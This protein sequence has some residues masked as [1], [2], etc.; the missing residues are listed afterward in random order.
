MFTTSGI[1]NKIYLRLITFPNLWS[2]T[3]KIIAMS[4]LNYHNKYFCMLGEN[5]SSDILGNSLI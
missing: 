2:S 1:S 3:L 4:A 5:A